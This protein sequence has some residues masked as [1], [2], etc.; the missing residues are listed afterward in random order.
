MLCILRVE[1]CSSS[2]NAELYHKF[3]ETIIIQQSLNLNKTACMMATQMGLKNVYGY[4]EVLS[5]CILYLELD[6]TRNTRKLIGIWTQLLKRWM[7][8]SLLLRIDMY[9]DIQKCDF[10]CFQG[11]NIADYSEYCGIQHSSEI[12]LTVGVNAYECIELV[13]S[14]SLSHGQSNYPALF[15]F[16]YL[17]LKQHYNRYSNN[18]VFDLRI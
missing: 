17:F 18:I 9:E 2:K 10:S 7:A 13:A 5:P 11:Y 15:G 12:A 14:L 1:Q 6:C 8:F 16:D 4:A 3:L